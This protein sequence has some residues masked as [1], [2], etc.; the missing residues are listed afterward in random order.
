[1]PAGKY[2]INLTADGA[3]ALAET[4]AISHDLA[5]GKSGVSR[6]K[7]KAVGTG[8]GSIAMAISGPGDFHLERTLRIGVRPPQL[9]GP[10]A[11]GRSGWRR[12]KA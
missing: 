11:H 1:M 4:P 2:D 10:R 9:A 5:V 6:V 7:I 3:V 8:E 12:A